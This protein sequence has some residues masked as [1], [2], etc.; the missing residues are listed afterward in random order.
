MIVDGS[1]A[2][3]AQMLVR[4]MNPQ[5]LAMDEITAEADVEALLWAA[6]CGVRLLAS[7]HGEDLSSLQRRKIYRELMEYNLF[8]RVVIVGEQNGVRSYQVEVIG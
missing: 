7:A 6:G 1:K 4:G 5:V 2:D 3:A 8:Q